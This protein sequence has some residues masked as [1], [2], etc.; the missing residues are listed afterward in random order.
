M[1]LLMCAVVLLV[2]AEQVRAKGRS[3]NEQAPVLYGALAAPSPLKQVVMPYDDF[4]QIIAKVEHSEKL[5]N[6]AIAEN[7]V[8]I[9]LKGEHEGIIKIQAEQIAACEQI[10][11]SQDR[12]RL[13]DAEIEGAIRQE[14]RKE[15]RL[16]R[17]KSELVLM[18]VVAIGLWVFN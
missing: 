1:K 2:C 7:G 8:L 9:K 12:L 17:Y 13:T 10:V 3:V 11:Q 5:K 6:K 4:L 15:R 18:G 14:L 16:S